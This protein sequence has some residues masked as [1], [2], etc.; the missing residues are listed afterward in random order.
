MKSNVGSPII[1]RP[2]VIIRLS[3]ILMA[4]AVA[5]TVLKVGMIG[6]IVLN[7]GFKIIDIQIIMLV[8][9][10]KLAL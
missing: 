7:Q 9:S 1:L 2:P 6:V 10:Q 3:N 5:T 4:G 8:R